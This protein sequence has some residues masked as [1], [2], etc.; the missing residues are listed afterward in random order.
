[1][2]QGQT[3]DYYN[4][5]E[6]NK[7]PNQRSLYFFITPNQKQKAYANMYVHISYHEMFDQIILKCIEHPQVPEDGKYLLEQY[8]ANLRETV[9]NSNMPM[10]LVNINLCKEI[11][12]SHSEVLDNIFCKAE[13]TKNLKESNDPAC[14]VYEH[15]QNILDEIYLSVDEKYGHTPNMK[16]QRQLVTFTELYNRGAVKEGMKFQM[17]YDGEMYY[18]KAI[19]SKNKKNCYLQVLDENQNP[20]RDK[21]TGTILGI[22][23]T[24]SSAGVDV[25]NFRREQKGIP[26]RI[27]TLRGT[28]YWVNENGMTLKELIEKF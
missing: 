22:Y 24:A 21:S 13:E 26:E 19:L 23:E 8:A 14:M 9:R 4:Y 20:Y 18:A 1:S 17:E 25:I 5:V 2:S 16:L 11:Y 7:K 3:M 15:Y 10:A 27:K 28:T 12:D 6:A